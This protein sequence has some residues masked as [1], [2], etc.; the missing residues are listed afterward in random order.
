MALIPPFFLDCVVAIGFASPEG[1]TE[2]C[3]TAFLYG[4]FLE[5]VGEKKRYRVY[6]VTNRHV[7]EGQSLAHLRFNPA[8]DDAARKYDASLV[9]ANGKQLWHG[10]T[11]PKVDLAALPINVELLKAQGI[12]LSYFQSDAHVAHRS[13]A[14]QNGVTEGD[15]VFVLGF[16]MG[17]IGDERNFVIVRQGAIARIRDTLAGRGQTF[18]VDAAIFPGNSGGPVVTRPEPMAIEGTKSMTKASLIGIVSGYLPYKDVAISPQTK[19]PRVI[20]E[21]NSGLAAVVPIDYL[22]EILTTIPK[23]PPT[24]LVAEPAAV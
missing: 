18:L 1:P 5:A 8:G 23:P 17:L 20:F 19:R 15:G 2:Y 16:P 22:S 12:Q 24:T 10:H 11:N 7:F 14:I 6:L 21:E 9:D 4:D 3:A 13:E